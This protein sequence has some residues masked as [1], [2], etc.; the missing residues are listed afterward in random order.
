MERKIKI[1]KRRWAELSHLQP[2]PTHLPLSVT[3][4]WGNCADGW[5]QPVSPS[6]G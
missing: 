1:L 5:G 4:P 6:R 3:Q 2:I